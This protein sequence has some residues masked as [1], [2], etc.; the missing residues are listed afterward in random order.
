MLRVLTF[1]S[2]SLVLSLTDYTQARADGAY[3]KTDLPPGIETCLATGLNELLGIN[4][5]DKRTLFQYFLGNI[6]IENFGNYNFKRAWRDWGQ[7]SEIKRLALYE[8]FQLMAGK[9]SEHQGGTTA[10]D[11][12]LADQPIVSGTNVYHIVARV[13]FADGSSTTIVLFTVGCKVFGFM[14]GGA[15]L[16]S[17]VDASMVERLYRSGK[18]APF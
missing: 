5:A 17:F 15:N 4:R 1:L 3:V 7:N 8:Y 2:V 12:R 11:A 16:R 6:D 18:R 10:I 13:D 9:R 14:Y